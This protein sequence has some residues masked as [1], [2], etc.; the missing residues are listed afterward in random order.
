VGDIVEWVPRE[1]IDS[2]IT[3]PDRRIGW[4]GL[5]RAKLDWRHWPVNG[6]PRML[7]RYD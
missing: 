6:A 2:E 5:I 7:C 4:V 1:F 3:G